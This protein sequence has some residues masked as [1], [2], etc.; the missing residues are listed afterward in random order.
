M[1]ESRALDAKVFALMASVAT[2]GRHR[3]ARSRPWEE[4]RC[5]RCGRPTIAPSQGL[6]PSCHQQFRLGAA[7][8]AAAARCLACETRDHRVLSTFSLGAELVALCRNCLH[9]LSS[10]VPWPAT[11]EEAVELVRAGAPVERPDAAERRSG[12]DRRRR[13]RRCGWRASSRARAR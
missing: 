10:A 1:D 3:P 8:P 4:V 11:L 6:C 7:P 5:Q 9:I 12:L 13:E 2:E